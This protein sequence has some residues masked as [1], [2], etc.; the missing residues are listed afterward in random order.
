LNFP[1][2][3]DPHGP[4]TLQHQLC[5][6]LRKAILGGRLV[7]GQRIPSSRT[8]AQTL[9]ISRTSV[10]LCYDQLVSEGYLESNRGS[11][12]FVCGQLPE[13]FLA[14]GGGLEPVPARHQVP[15]PWSGYGARLLTLDFPTVDRVPEAPYR[16]TQ[17]HPPME[18]FPVDTWK[19]LLARHC[20]NRGPALTDFRPESTGCEVLRRAIADY[21]Q[22]SRAVRCTPDQVLVLGSS[23]QGVGLAARTLVDPGDRVAMEDP[24]YPGAR[25][26][27]L[28]HGARILAL[29]AGANGVS[30]LPLA[31]ERTCKLVYVTPSHQFPTGTTMG[32]AQRLELLA[33]CRQHG[34]MLLEDDYDSEFRY[35]GRPLPATQG[36]DDQG[37][38]LYLGTFSKAL[39]PTLRLGYLVAPPGQVRVLAR[40]HQLA[41]GQPP[42]LEQYALADFITEGHLERHVRRMRTAYGRRR[43]ALLS[44]LEQELGDRVEVLGEPAGMH[45]M[46]RF[47]TG[48]ADE[49]LTRRAAALGVALAP[50]RRC[51]LDPGPQ[52]GF[53]MSFVAID[54]GRIRQGVRQLARVL[55]A[56]GP[57]GR[58]SGP[59]V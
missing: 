33:W 56:S 14:Q 47:R 53:L 32:L 22:R 4:E 30:L 17:T 28:A 8:L 51:F 7:R 25:Q 3:L 54:E 10:V 44:A 29:P 38:V 13:E 36:L 26:T 34:A 50:A 59:I 23:L 11:G 48:L 20:R 45:M 42:F 58:A 12:T 18:S 46:V 39:F 41:N 52:A 9:A 15:A 55:D 19:R 1:V 31:G 49:A 37:T 16:F 40:A 43:E 6:E 35:V 57:G 2:L 24:A 27:F 5:Q 21:L